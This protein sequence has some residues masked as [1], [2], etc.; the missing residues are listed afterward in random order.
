MQTIILLA[1]EWVKWLTE[2]MA[3]TRKYDNKL[4]TLKYRVN[5]QSLC[6]YL[7]KIL[8]HFNCSNI[9]FLV[10]YRS[11]TLCAFVCVVMVTVWSSTFYNSHWDAHCSFFHSLTA[12]L[13]WAY[14]THTYT[15]RLA[16][17]MFCFSVS[18]WS[19]FYFFGNFGWT[20]GKHTFGHHSAQQTCHVLNAFCVH[21]FL[22]PSSSFSIMLQCTYTADGTHDLL[23]ISISA[24]CAVFFG[25]SIL[26]F[27]IVYSLA[28]SLAGLLSH[29]VSFLFVSISLVPSFFHSNLW[30]FV[31]ACVIETLCIIPSKTE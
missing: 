30:F 5:F 13:H 20:V 1:A 28:C 10:L 25:V 4:R 26:F 27:F 24:M 18:S 15:A 31:C 2:D 9:L 22:A 11:F 8:F 12:E 14:K 17:L 29:F 23:I 6:F 19:L 21:M 3:N 16:R 7:P